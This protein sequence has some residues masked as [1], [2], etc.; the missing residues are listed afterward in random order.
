MWYLKSSFETTNDKPTLLIYGEKDPVHQMGISTRIERMLKKA[1]LKLIDG[2]MHFPF[3][4]EYEQ[5]SALID[6][7]VKAG[8]SVT[9]PKSLSI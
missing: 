4:G 8:H 2:E 3:E 5:I 9:Y 7:W 1:Q 6:Q